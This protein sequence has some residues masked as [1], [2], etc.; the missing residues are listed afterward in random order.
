MD[1]K[2]NKTKT[3]RKKY[4]DLKAYVYREREGITITGLV[5]LGAVSVLAG[6]YVTK[7]DHADINV[8]NKTKNIKETNSEDNNISWNEIENADVLKVKTS[9]GKEDILFVN[10]ERIIVDGLTRYNVTDVL[11]E[12]PT[13]RVDGNKQDVLSD[14]F[15]IEEHLGLL[16]NYLTVNNYIENSYSK[17]GLES[18]RLEIK[19]T[20]LYNKNKSNSKKRDKYNFNHKW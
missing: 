17:D 8:T 16:T 1:G 19:S 4:E 2:D 15:T 10:Y 14:S 13:F 3:L 11:K 9:D 12:F 18:F 5:I 6:V 20:E 7:K